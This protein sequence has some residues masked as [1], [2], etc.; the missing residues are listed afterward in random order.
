MLHNL[1]IA[2]PGTADKVGQQSLA[3]GLNAEKLNYIPNSADILYH[4][5]LL[6]PKES[7]TIYFTAPEKPGDYVYICTYP[8]HFVVMRGILKVF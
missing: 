2:L 8:G 1:V 3:L 5:V 6:H 7:D 4:T